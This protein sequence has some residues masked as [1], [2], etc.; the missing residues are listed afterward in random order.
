MTWIHDKLAEDLADH[1]GP[2]PFLNVFLGSPVNY[3]MASSTWVHSNLP[4][5]LRE[6]AIAIGEPQRADVVKIHPSYTKFSVS[7]YE[8]KVSRS[9]FLSDIRKEKWRGYLPHCNRF[10]FAVAEGV[11]T[12]QDIPEEAGLMIR[13]AKGWTTVKAAPPNDRDIPRIT[14]MSLVFARQRQTVRERRTDRV[15][16]A[17][18]RWDRRKQLKVFGQRIAEALAKQANYEDA[19]HD[20][21]EAV[22]TIRE[23]VRD[24]LG[25]DPGER[26]P[27]WDLRKLVRKIKERATNGADT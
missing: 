19:T 2:L 16:D 23:A 27:E 18:G 11:A 8:I 4:E 21:K 13:G 26:W 17:R 22:E 24:G 3:S 6:E 1:I 25:S 7:I 12:K 5:N 10:Y 15:M 9:D 14:L 20:L